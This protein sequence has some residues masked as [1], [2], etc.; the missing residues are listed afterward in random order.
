MKLQ[1][2]R[3]AGA[4]VVIFASLWIIASPFLVLALPFIRNTYD[5]SGWALT[6]YESGL[7]CVLNFD[8]SD[9]VAFS[10]LA[11]FVIIGVVGVFGGIFLFRRDST[12]RHFA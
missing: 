2:R 12:Q 11:V 5:G 10:W 8:W 4:L 3:F 1:H 6:S 7:G 9:R